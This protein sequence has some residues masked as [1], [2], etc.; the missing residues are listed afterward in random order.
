MTPLL[1]ENLFRCN[2]NVSDIRNCF[3]DSFWRDVLIAW[4]EF[5]YRETIDKS[6]DILAQ[7]I[8]YNSNIRI[9]NKVVKVNRKAYRKGLRTVFDLYSDIMERLSASEISEKYGIDMMFANAIISALPKDWRKVISTEII[10]PTLTTYD[11]F[12]LEKHPVRKFYTSCNQQSYC[13]HDKYVKWQKRLNSSISF[14]DFLMFF[15]NIRKCTNHS[16]LRSFQYRLLNDAIVTNV[17]LERWKVLSSDECSF[18]HKTAETITHLLWECEKVQSLW[19]KIREFCLELK[20]NAPF[21]LE[22]SKIIFNIVHPVANHVFN[23]IVLVVKTRIYTKR[24]LKQPLE[25]QDIIRFV[26]QCQQIEKYNAIQNNKIHVYL[27]KWENV[28]YNQTTN[29]AKE[30]FSE[31]HIAEQYIQQ[32]NFFKK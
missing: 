15:K 16:K 21:E 32:V 26:K 28:G 3:K 5:N 24:C 19:Y 22:L 27:K 10:I 31:D 23:F 1:Q 12:M 18:C 4:S 6:E 9:D 14:K 8:W 2:I 13:V 29:I 11:S 25:G 30:V 17:L 20:S 7:W